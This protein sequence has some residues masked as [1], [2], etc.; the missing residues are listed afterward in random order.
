MYPHP[1]P[2]PE[3]M[4]SIRLNDTRSFEIL[5]E[6]YW[7]PLYRFVFSKLNSREA[8]LE[9]TRNTF[10]EIWEQR[11]SIPVSFSVHAYLYDRVRKGV[12]CQLHRR[13]DEDA[14]LTG[15]E[16][17]LDK[18]LSIEKLKSAYQPVKNKGETLRDVSTYTLRHGMQENLPFGS[19]AW[20]VQWRVHLHN[21]ITGFRKT[22]L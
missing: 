17:F 1:V 9:I 8:A 13:L 15:M 20:N 19:P 18:E 11:A 14:G 22:F 4:E 12:I 7:F 10:I 21:V 6:K 16:D 2:D 5:I 3:L